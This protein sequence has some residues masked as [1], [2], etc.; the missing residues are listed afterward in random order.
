[1]PKTRSVRAAH[2]L[3]VPFSNIDIQ[4]ECQQQSYG[5]NPHTDRSGGVKLLTKLTSLFE[6]RAVKGRFRGVCDYD[7]R[8]VLVVLR[9]MGLKGLDFRFVVRSGGILIEVMKGDGLTRLIRGPL[10]LASQASLV[11]EP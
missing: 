1:M 9:W 6:E 7:A 2:L 4:P 5:N 8:A 11:I 3:L 10:P